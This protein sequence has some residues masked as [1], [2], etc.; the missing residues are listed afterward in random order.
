[1]MTDNVEPNGR[2]IDALAQRAV[3]SFMT[4]VRR[5]TA[6]AGGAL[7]I[8]VVICLSGFLLGVAAL[9]DGIQTVWIV[10]GGTFAIIGIGA[11]ALAIVRLLRVRN[12]AVALVSEVH[13]LIAGDARSERVV[14]ETLESSDDVQDQSAVVMSRQFFAMQDS[15]GGRT[16]KFK[17]LSEALKA[18]TSFPMLMLLSVLVTITFAGFALIF[19]LALAI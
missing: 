15:V 9:S 19:A 16:D 6:L 18:I 11:V 3:D 1:M 13:D 17:A 12:H 7:A 4:L 10:L 14:I 8:V 2:N 5:G